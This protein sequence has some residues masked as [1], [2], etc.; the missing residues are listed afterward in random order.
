MVHIAFEGRV[1]VLSACQAITKDAYPADYEFDYDAPDP[2][3]RG[4]SMIVDPL[5]NVLAGPVFGEETILYADIDLD[6]KTR[7]HIDMDATGHYSRP[8]VFSLSVD[9]RSKASVELSG[10]PSPRG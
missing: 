1:F 6:A 10:D 2:V 9:T 3:M 7:G 8:D 4:G 5:G